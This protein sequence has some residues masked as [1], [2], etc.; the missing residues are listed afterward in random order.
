MG[1]IEGQVSWL[2]QCGVKEGQLDALK[3]LMDEMVAGTSQ[4]PGALSYEW[5]I[6]DDNA[7]VH[8]YE[9][10]VD[11]AATVA[12]MQAFGEKWAGR[13]MGCLDVQRVTV[14]GDPDEMAQKA[15]APMGG[16]QLATWGGFGR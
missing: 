10:Y 6:S 16:K 14:Y 4:E 13:F 15:I 9:K 1:S 7:S 5:F 12:H 11:S 3:E 2:V 8:I